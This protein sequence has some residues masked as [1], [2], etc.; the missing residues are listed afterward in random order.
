MMRSASCRI[1]WLDL[2]L[3]LAS[4]NTWP[5]LAALAADFASNGTVKSVILWNTNDLGY[6]TVQVARGLVDNK[7]KPGD[8]KFDAGK[9]GEKK[10]VGDNVLLG[11]ILVFTKDN[12]DKF[13]F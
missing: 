4:A 2:A 10:V 9:I 8:T 7:L 5:S 1:T 13:N 11:D 3:R 6:L 12:I